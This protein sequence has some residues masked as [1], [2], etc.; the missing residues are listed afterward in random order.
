MLPVVDQ[1]YAFLLIIGLGMLMGLLFDF[2]RTI[3]QVY[4][5]GRWGTI[6]G[7]TVF[8]LIIT[9]VTYAFLLLSIWGEVRFYVFLAL[10]AGVWIYLKYLSP[11]V[12]KILYRCFLILISAVK[13][14]IKIILTPL[15]ICWR[16]FLLPFRFVTLFFLVIS[17]GLRF[18]GQLI[19]TVP[20]R[21]KKRLIPPGNP[22]ENLS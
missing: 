20:R 1:I 7:D 14:M 19:I 21:I 3:R 6:I 12:L 16:F 17:R 13:L 15:R 22:P 9:G 8:W 5:P 2:Y 10:G 11:S 18:F 4:K